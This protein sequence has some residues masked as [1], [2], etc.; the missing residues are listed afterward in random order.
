MMTT[1]PVMAARCAGLVVAL[2]A[3]LLAGPGARAQNMSAMEVTLSTSASASGLSGVL[4]QLMD[5][6]M[7]SLA[8][9]TERR[10]RQIASPFDADGAAQAASDPRPMTEAA[11]DALPPASGDDE[12]HCLTEALY[13]EARGEPVEGLYAVAEVILNRVD[14]PA[15]PGSVCAVIAQGTGRLFACQFTFTCDGAP[16]RVDDAVAWHRLGQVARIMLDGAPRDLTQGATHYHAGWVTPRW[17]S[18]YPRTAAIGI[19]HFYRRQY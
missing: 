12:W 10:I 15:F 13:F 3:A 1:T 16:E 14:H 19:H 8:G 4:E 7:A 6:E 17:A 9:L 11:L 5:M 2:G 18:L